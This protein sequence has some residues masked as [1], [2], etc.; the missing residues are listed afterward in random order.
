LQQTAGPFIVTVFSTQSPLRTGPADL[1]TLV[2]SAG[3]P[4]PIMNARVFIELRNGADAIIS[5][6]ATHSQARN[7]LLYCSLI[8]FKEAGNWK[9]KITVELGGER[10][11]MMGD[12]TVARPQPMLFSYWKLFAFP[13]AII[14]LF[15]FNQWLRRSRSTLMN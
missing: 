10:A 15:V 5:S 9:M 8:N 1:S 7:K 3:E 4:S 6:E 13:P 12:L 14:I 2:E 11:E